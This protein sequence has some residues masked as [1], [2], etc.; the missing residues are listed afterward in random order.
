MLHMQPKFVLRSTENT[1]TDK[2]YEQNVESL[3][4]KSGRT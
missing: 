3:L 2:L 1:K 4:L